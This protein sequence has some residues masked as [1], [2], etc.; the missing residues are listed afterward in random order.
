MWVPASISKKLAREV[1]DA[2][3]RIA[4]GLDYCGVL[5]VEVFISTDDRVLVG[6]K[7]Y[8]SV[9]GITLLTADAQTLRLNANMIG[10][11]KTAPKSL[12]PE[13]LIDGLSDQQ[14]ADLITYLRSL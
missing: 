11:M 7:I 13:G 4:D 3:R 14:V 5:A 12:M 6:M 10:E 8:E 2:A 9:D 1:E